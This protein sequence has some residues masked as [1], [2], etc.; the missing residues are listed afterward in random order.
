MGDHELLQH[1]SLSIEPGELV[2]LGGG[3]RSGQDHAARDDGRSPPTDLGKRDLRRPRRRRS[4]PATSGSC[5]RTTSSTAGS[6]C[7]GRFAT[8]PG[9]ACP[10]TAHQATVDRVVDDTL[11]DLELAERRDV[12]VGQLSGGQRK[13]ASIAV[14]LLT[15]PRVFFLDE[16]TS[17]LDPATSA[18]VLTVLRRLAD[19]GVTVV[20]TTHDPADIEA[21]DRVVFLAPHGH[22]AFAGT[23]DDAAP[24]LRGHQPR[25]RLPVPRTRGRTRTVGCALRRQ[26]RAGRSVGARGERA[27]AAVSPCGS[28]A[29]GG[30]AHAAQ[31]GRPRSE[32]AH[33]R[34]PHR[35]T[36][37][38]D[39]DDGRALQSRRLRAV[40]CR[41]TR[42]GADDLLGRVRWILLRPDVRAAADRRR[43]LGV[44]PRAVGG[45]ECRC[46]P[47]LQGRGAATAA[48]GRERR[49]ARGAP[50]IGS[51]ARRQPRDLRGAAC[52][53]DDRVAVCPGTRI[54]HVRGGRR[55]RTGHARAAN[56]LLP[57]GAVRRCGRALR[58]DGGAR[59]GDQ[60]RDGESLGVRV[61]RAG[62]RRRY[63]RHGISADELRGTRSQARR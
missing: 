63:R 8:Q 53:A 17:G 35:F 24:L 61:A 38:R 3:Q 20:L 62:A 12:P 40:G 36:R 56:A 4:D 27:D 52:D 2:A 41:V 54:A 45:I 11:Q 60:L 43:V 10:P 30:A 59:P 34:G 55:R 32:P 21:C 16:P 49:D 26:R 13:R 6:R 22:L 44:S 15:R 46:L 19:R 25:A 47:R 29:S 18:D 51:T 7:D 23:P 14:E 28:T 57:A 31:R 42:S 5:P 39:L 58:R 33:A 1:I 50:R 48:D 9:S 37:S